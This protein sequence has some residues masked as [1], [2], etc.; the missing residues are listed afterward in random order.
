VR[1]EEAEERVADPMVVGCV[2]SVVV[3]TRGADGAGEIAVRV[4]GGVETFLAWS[5]EALP[6][7]APVLVIGTLGPRTV[8]VVE[9]TESTITFEGGR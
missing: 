1:P 7:G 5:D 8:E 9:W 4:R 3:A 2:G 6:R